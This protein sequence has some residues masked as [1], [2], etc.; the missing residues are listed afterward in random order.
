MLL[1]EPT[2]RLGEMTEEMCV[3]WLSTYL[4][5]PVNHKYY[6]ILKEIFH[7]SF[8]GCHWDT[9]NLEYWASNLERN[10]KLPITKNY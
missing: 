4:E 6:G 3:E 5:I 1:S 7:K 2:E 9:D 8:P 10:Y